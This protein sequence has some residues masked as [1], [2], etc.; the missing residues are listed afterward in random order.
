MH[1][2]HSVTVSCQCGKVTLSA[3]GPPIL[4]AACYCTSCQQ[5]GHQLEQLPSAPPIRDADG[6]TPVVLYRKDR[7][8]CLAG[9]EYLKEHRLKPDSPSRRVFATCCNSGMFGDFTRGHWLSI[10]R[11]RLSAGAPPLEMRI[12]T[13][14]RRTDAVLA[15]DVPN[16]EGYPGKFMLKLIAARIAMGFGKHNTALRNLPRSG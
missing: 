12:M 5:A 7:I 9:L 2:Q 8:Q 15:N 3:A 1:E 13:K 16:H 4:T 11:K 10:Y 6:G 14:E